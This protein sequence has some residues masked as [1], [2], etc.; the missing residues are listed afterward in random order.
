MLVVVHVKFVTVN[1]DQLLPR[2]PRDV[3]HIKPVSFFIEPVEESSAYRFENG[4]V[5]GP[6]AFFGGG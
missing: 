1:Y 2:I 3:G 5:A 4:Y 6:V